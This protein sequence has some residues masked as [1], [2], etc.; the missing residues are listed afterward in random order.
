MI[1]AER[2]P[3]KNLEKSS[4]LD[5]CLIPES[6]SV[7]SSLNQL[8]EIEKLLEVSD[9]ISGDK[10]GA[11]SMLHMVLWDELPDYYKGILSDLSAMEMQESI[12]SK[13]SSSI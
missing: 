10:W 1:E 6:E 5:F 3:I 2:P 11:L 9:E 8:L 12:Y 13:T 4:P 7:R